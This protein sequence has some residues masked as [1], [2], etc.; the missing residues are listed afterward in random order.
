[1]QAAA[2]V[3]RSSTASIG[4]FQDKLP[5]EKEARGIAEI[6]PG[7]TRKRKLPPVPGPVEKSENLN[8]IDS[9]LNKKP[10]LDIE[11]AVARQIN[12]ENLQ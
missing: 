2:T 6:T 7:A 8:I 4:K 3:A 10:K 9:I 12:E 11:K 1:M 5:K